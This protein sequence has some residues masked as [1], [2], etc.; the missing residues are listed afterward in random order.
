MP[1]WCTFGM[2]IRFS[3]KRSA[4]ACYSEL[5]ER[6]RAADA[7]H[8]GFQ[9]GPDEQYLFDTDMD[10]VDDLEISIYGDVKWGFDNDMVAAFFQYAIDKGWNI[11]EAVCKYEEISCCIYGKWIYNGDNKTLTDWRVLESYIN[12]LYE[13]ATQEQ[14]DS[15][16][17]L[18]YVEEKAFNAPDDQWEI[19]DSYQFD[20]PKKESDNGKEA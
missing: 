20:Q 9:F 10:F 18:G 11:S 5:M 15:D 2:N 6:K 8:E 17:W 7:R 13:N 3:D 19:A 16:F 14:Q 12:S 4:Q 1:N